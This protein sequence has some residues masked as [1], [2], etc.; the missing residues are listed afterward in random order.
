MS[1]VGKKPIPIPE[2]VEVKIEGQKVTVN[3]PKGEAS[4]QFSSEVKIALEDKKLLVSLAKEGKESQAIWGSSRA[5]LN[6][7]IKGVKEGFE[8]KLEVEGLGFKVTLTGGNL[9]LFVGFTNSI[10]IAPPEGIK[11]STEKNVITVSGNDLEK[12]SLTAAK[13]KRM[14]KPE[15]YKGS[16]IRYQGEQIRRKEGKKAVATTK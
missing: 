16:G 9:E 15:P 7:M 12:V 8:R 3:G 1:R 10:K 14:R 13:I 6:N 5:N 4:R 2:G 11:F